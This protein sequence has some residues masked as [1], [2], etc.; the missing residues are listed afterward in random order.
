MFTLE[1]YFPI[2]SRQQCSLTASYSI[3]SIDPLI[4][5]QILNKFLYQTQKKHHWHCLLQTL[6]IFWSVKSELRYAFT[7]DKHED[8]ESKIGRNSKAA[9]MS[10]EI[11]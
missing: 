1:I 3:L 8:G 10:L 5:R 2:Y 9:E 6:S 7:R 4:N 11:E